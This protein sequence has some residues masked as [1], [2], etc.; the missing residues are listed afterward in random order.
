MQPLQLLTLLAAASLPIAQACKC[1]DLSTK[2]NHF[3]GTMG[4]CGEWGGTFIGDDCAARSLSK[5]MAFFAGCCG[6]IQGSYYRSD[7]KF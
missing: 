3:E 1:I 7:C 4:C 6:K 2:Q 5:N